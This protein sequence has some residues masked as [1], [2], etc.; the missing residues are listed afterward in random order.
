MTTEFR[1]Q[2]GHPTG[3][4]LRQGRDT[5]GRE[6]RYIPGSFAPQSPGECFPNV[7]RSCFPVEQITETVTGYETTAWTNELPGV[8][9]FDGT[10]VDTLPN[11]GDAYGLNGLRFE[12]ND[13]LGSDFMETVFSDSTGD[14][15][16]RVPASQPYEQYVNGDRISSGRYELSTPFSS[17]LTPHELYK[18]AMHGGA[19]PD[20]SHV[21]PVEVDTIN[22]P[23]PFQHGYLYRQNGL[24]F[25][26]YHV[27]LHEEL[28]P[29]GVYITHIRLVLNGEVAGPLTEI[30]PGLRSKS[31]YKFPTTYT[32]DVIGEQ[33]GGKDRDSGRRNMLR[34]T[35]YPVPFFEPIKI[36]PGD[37]VGFD[38][39]LRINRDA[40]GF[41]TIGGPPVSGPPVG[42][43]LEARSKW[44]P[45]IMNVEKHNPPAY[46]GP[47]SDDI[48]S[49]DRVPWSEHIKKDR[50]WW[51][52]GNAAENYSSTRHTYEADFGT[53]FETIWTPTESQTFKFEAIGGVAV[54]NSDCRVYAQDAMPK[55][56]E[57]GMDWN[58]ETCA[59]ILFAYGDLTSE[60]ALQHHD[61]NGQPYSIY[62]VGYYPRESTD[63]TWVAAYNPAQ[64]RSLTDWPEGKARVP[65]PFNQEGE[66]TFD[67]AYIKF[68]GRNVATG[69]STYIVTIHSQYTTRVG[70]TSSPEI[71][72]MA[73]V[74]ETITVTRVNQ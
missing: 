31:F 29:H 36:E 74:A 66:T 11:P 60:L 10:T 65:G 19:Y 64:S 32:F 33:V 46:E 8:F 2:S 63:A 17:V 30:G 44:P 72:P 12:C 37:M 15:T 20:L 18:A 3:A 26:N 54:S 13:L 40:Y 28:E 22:V 73:N 53:E 68:Q 51:T 27:T 5:Y 14:V 23:M 42:N 25:V 57:F 55:T 41:R 49:L 9:W 21:G 61:V 45:D 62:E 35:T 48:S 38:I 69:G 71:G 58:G 59:M 16:Q 56:Y 34:P 52:L 50:A 6:L 39:W 7:Y 24:P 1:Y 43:S 47:A 67:L 4:V 70:S